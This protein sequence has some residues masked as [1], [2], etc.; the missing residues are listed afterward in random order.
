MHRKMTG[1]E[2]AQMTAETLNGKYRVHQLYWG[3]RCGADD[4]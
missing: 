2:A 1:V 3:N 4:N